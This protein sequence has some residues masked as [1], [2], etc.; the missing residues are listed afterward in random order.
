MRAESFTQT[1]AKKSL[2][3]WEEVQQPK[4]L[5]A[6]TITEKKLVGSRVPF[7]LCISLVVPRALLKAL[8]STKKGIVTS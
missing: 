6:L 5:S 8:G 4:L 3:L 7:N 2:V 1:A